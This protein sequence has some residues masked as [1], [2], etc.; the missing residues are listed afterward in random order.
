MLKQLIFKSFS[1]K[2]SF[3]VV[4]SAIV[5]LLAGASFAGRPPA[6]VGGGVSASRVERSIGGI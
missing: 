4:L 3:F 2:D 1:K 5:K 6:A